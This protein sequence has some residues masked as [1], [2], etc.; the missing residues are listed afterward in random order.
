MNYCN[1]VSHL[2]KYIPASQ[3]PDGTWRK[4][5]RVK[6]GYVPQEEVPL[7]ESKGKLFMKKPAIPVGMCPTIVQQARERR[8]KQQPHQHQQQRQNPIPGLYVLPQANNRTEPKKQ[9]SN[10]KPSNGLTSS[11]KNSASST[12]KTNV[13]AINNKT[14]ASTTA[15]TA[16]AAVAASNRTNETTLSGKLKNLDISA[17]WSTFDSTD[18][19]IRHF[20]LLIFF[21]KFLTFAAGSS[22]GGEDD[23]TKKIKKFRKKLREIE[24]IEAK[25]AS[26]ELKK[27]DADQMEK[28]SRKKQILEQL[29]E[30]EQLE[31]K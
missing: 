31:N 2:G 22:T 17:G 27:P 29:K 5:R 9:Q 16:T 6:D 13:V 28:V 7:Y 14:A 25:L 26:G 1:I 30:L 20:Y 23:V 24:S 21:F 3:R 4:A 15:T 19:E 18:F 10:A 11:N 8:D 12:K